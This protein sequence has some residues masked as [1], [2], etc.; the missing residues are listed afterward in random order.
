M[1]FK[2]RGHL[3]L[4]LYKTNIYICPI[5]EMSEYQKSV[6]GYKVVDREIE[7]VNGRCAELHDDKLGKLIF[8]GIRFLDHDTCSHEAFHCVEYVME[9]IGCNH[10]ESSSEAWAYLLGLVTSCIYMVCSGRSRYRELDVFAD[11]R[12]AR[13]KKRKKSI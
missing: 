12:S 3:Y 6:V 5:E 8:I 2:N 11:A 10:S 7:H 9:K 13:G 1:K 4:A